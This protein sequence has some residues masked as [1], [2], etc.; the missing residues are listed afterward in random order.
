MSSL[1][2]NSPHMV[3][4]AVTIPAGPASIRCGESGTVDSDGAK[5]FTSFGIRSCKV[6]K[7]SGT[8]IYMAINRDATAAATSVLLPA[9]PT[10]LDVDIDDLAKLR[11]IGTAADVVQILARI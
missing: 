2:E 11:F 7:S 1:A 3:I 5:T 8:G 6:T 4:L 9:A 10:M